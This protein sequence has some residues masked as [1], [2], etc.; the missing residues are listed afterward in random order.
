MRIREKIQKPLF[1]RPAAALSSLRKYAAKVGLRPRTGFE[2]NQE[3]TEER[4]SCSGWLSPAVAPDLGKTYKTGR[5]NSYDSEY[6]PRQSLIFFF[7]GPVLKRP[8]RIYGRD[9]IDAVKSSNAILKR[10]AR[11]EHRAS[12]TAV[13][14]PSGSLLGSVLV[15]IQEFCKRNRL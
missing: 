10:R 15:R 12:F 5:L 7:F 6:S 3:N 11:N 14:S 13:A 2:R 9:L 8:L 1:G 4:R